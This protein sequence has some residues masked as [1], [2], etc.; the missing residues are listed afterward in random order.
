VVVGV[1]AALAVVLLA[2]GIPFLY[3]NV[4][5]DDAPDRL[6]ASGGE[7][8]DGS[9]TAGAP[10]GTVEGTWVVT[11]GTEVGY[12]V[13]EV[14]MGQDAEAVGRTDAVTGE[15]AVEGAE[16]TSAS[17]EVDMTSVTSDEARRDNQFQGRIME[18]STYPTATFE[19]TEP[20]DVSAIVDGTA[21][22]APA[23]GELTLHGTTQPVTVDLTV[24]PDGDTVSVS[25]AIPVTFADYGIP[26]PSFGPVTTED[27]GEIEVLLVLEHA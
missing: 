21:T 22:T 7:E 2:V 15:L 11:D 17:F 19:L 18:T 4:I 6:S 14:L 9:G 16:I 1:A 3:T 20:I 5:A 8:G 27:T 12:R 10:A 13:K 26:N 23:A 25:G 24:Q